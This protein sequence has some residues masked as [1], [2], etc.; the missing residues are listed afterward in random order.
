MLELAATQDCNP[1]THC[2]G[3]DLI[4][5]DVDGRGLWFALQASNVKTHSCAQLRVK[6]GKRFVHEKRSRFTYD[7]TT[8]CNPLP[9][10]ARKGARF[11]MV[12]FP[13]VICSRP[14]SILS[15]GVMPHPGGPTSPMNSPSR[16][17]R[18]SLFTAWV[19][20]SKFF[21][22]WSWIISAMLLVPMLLVRLVREQFEPENVS[23]NGGALLAAF[24]SRLVL[25]VA[26]SS[27][28]TCP[29]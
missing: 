12:I 1:I 24:L 5:R 6:I 18:L 25:R 9:L 3:F 22:T 19:P 15:A 28:T 8:H 21:D 17:C 16:T 27:T 11:P 29:P 14:A 10:A 7:R 23:D 20:S 2:H 26:S 13:S 4:V